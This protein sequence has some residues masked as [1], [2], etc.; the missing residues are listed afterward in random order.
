MFYRLNSHIQKHDVTNDISDDRNTT[1]RYESNRTENYDRERDRAQQL[2]EKHYLRRDVTN[3]KLYRS[4][5][6]QQVESMKETK[7]RKTA[8]QSAVVA[9]KG[10]YLGDVALILRD[11]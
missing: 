3:K 8:R 10:S 9:L 11:V 2:S 4:Q 6:R 1:Q 5:K 7:G